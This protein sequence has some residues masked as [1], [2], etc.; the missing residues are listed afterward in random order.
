MSR[1]TVTDIRPLGFQW[2]TRD[3]FLFCA[4]HEDHYPQ[5]NDDMGPDADLSGRNIGQDFQV[6]DGW[7]MYHGRKVPGFPGHPHRGFETVTIVRRGWVDHTDSKGA[8]GRYGEGDV[9]WMTAGKG[10]QHAEMFPLIDREGPNT[11]ELFQIWLNLPS[12][13]KMVEPY[14]KMLW[15]DQI[16]MYR[17]RDAQG[18]STQVEVV[19][20]KLGGVEPP[21]SPPDSWA[22]REE[23][24]VAIWNIKMEADA[25]WELPPTAAGIHRDLYFYQG[26]R[27]LAAEAELPAYHTAR[28]EPTE[29]VT[30]RAGGQAAGI[31]LLQGRPI[32]EP[33]AQHGPFV[34]NTREEILATFD[35]Y[36][37]TE[38]GGWP[39]PVI[40]PVHSREKGRFARHA[41]GRYESPT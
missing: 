33:V 11:L 8:A 4:H 22:A 25:V 17:H 29:T 10:L 19:A 36:R 37:K 40:D 6:K 32:G 41:D 16:P 31:L 30:L 3:P 35:D 7:R 14:F 39:W 1:N 13:K 23:N 21:M 38:F 34:M 28:L 12:A 2:T 27:L 18:R 5:G 24:G 26:D 15:S 20:G 9:Q